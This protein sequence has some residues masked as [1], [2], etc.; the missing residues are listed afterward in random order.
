MKEEEKR[1]ED[2]QTGRNGREKRLPSVQV[3]ISLHL[4]TRDPLSQH[5]HHACCIAPC[6]Y[7]FV[8]AGM[9]EGRKG[10]GGIVKTGEEKEKGRPISTIP[11]RNPK[12]KTGRKEGE[13]RLRSSFFTQKISPAYRASPETDLVP[14]AHQGGIDSFPTAPETCTRSSCRLSTD[15]LAYQRSLLR[16]PL[17]TPTEMLSD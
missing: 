6:L 11:F 4:S 15:I 9:Q 12:R 1:R 14:R 3:S 17:Q 16:G 5:F 8:L 7:I 13:E 2:K 10:E